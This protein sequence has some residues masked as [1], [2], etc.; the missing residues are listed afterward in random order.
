MWPAVGSNII[1]QTL[2]FPMGQEAVL[3][4]LLLANEYGVIINYFG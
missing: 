3:P 2:F 4:L 1:K